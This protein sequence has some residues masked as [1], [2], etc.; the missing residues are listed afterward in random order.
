MFF[1]I[2]ETMKKDFTINELKKLV[3]GHCFS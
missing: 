3:G 2:Q 1:C